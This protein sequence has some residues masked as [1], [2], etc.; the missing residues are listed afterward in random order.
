MTTAADLRKP[1]EL[2]LPI[3]TV[4]EANQREHWAF[5]SKR[6]KEQRFACAMAIRPHAYRLRG[7]IPIVVTLT[8][9]STGTLDTDNLA[10]AFKSC[11]DGI[12]DAIGVNDR[13]T[14]RVEYRYAQR[15]GKRGQRGI[16]IRIET[17]G[18]TT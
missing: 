13:D 16:E 4:S 18:A 8:R 15:K 1:V 10:G 2:A 6:H 12:A 9:I 11:R 17:R 14:E 5:K 7:M 3:L